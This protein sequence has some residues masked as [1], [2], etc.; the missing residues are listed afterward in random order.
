MNKAWY[1]ILEYTKI[2]ALAHI[3]TKLSIIENWPFYGPS[4]WLNYS[5]VV[6]I[7]E[8]SGYIVTV[9]GASSWSL[10]LSIVL[11][12]SIITFCQNWPCYPNSSTTFFLKYIFSLIESF[13]MNKKY[14]CYSRGNMLKSLIESFDWLVFYHVKCLGR[15]FLTKYVEHDLFNWNSK[16][17]FKYLA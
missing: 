7:L 13:H 8:R 11:S 14:A 3:F 10:S 16:K 9:N 1:T 6:T 15:Y 4:N 5:N 12:L 2:I 17:V